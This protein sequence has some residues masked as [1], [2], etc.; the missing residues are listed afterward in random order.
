MRAHIAKRLRR[1]GVE[2][3]IFFHQRAAKRIFDLFAAPKF[4]RFFRVFAESGAQVLLHAQWIDQC[5][6]DIES[7]DRIGALCFAMEI[8][9]AASIS[10]SQEPLGNP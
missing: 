5:P 3:L 4:G 10:G 7:Q 6:V 2:V 9:R 8:P 1:A